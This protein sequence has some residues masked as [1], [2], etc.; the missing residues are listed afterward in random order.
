MATVFILFSR[1]YLLLRWSVPESAFRRNSAMEYVFVSMGSLFGCECI[2]CK[3]I[4][5]HLSK[6]SAGDP[7]WGSV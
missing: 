4:I 1:K 3:I 7:Y 5:K 6:L 2:A